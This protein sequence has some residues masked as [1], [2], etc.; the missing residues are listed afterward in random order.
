M[1]EVSAFLMGSKFC[2]FGQPFEIGSIC[3]SLIGNGVV[4]IGSPERFD[5]HYFLQSRTFLS[6][7]RQSIE[8]VQARVGQ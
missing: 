4:Q 2:V 3:S 6:A 1:E 8:A 5:P 7:N